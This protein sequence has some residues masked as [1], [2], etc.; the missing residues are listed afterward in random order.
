MVWE[1]HITKT[2]PLIEFQVLE[3]TLS[4]NKNFDYWTVF[5]G[6]RIYFKCFFVTRQKLV[7]FQGS[8]FDAERRMVPWGTLVSKWT[9]TNVWAWAG[10]AWER[11]VPAPQAREATLAILPRQLPHIARETHIPHTITTATGI[12]PSPE[13]WQYHFLMVIFIWL[14]QQN[15]IVLHF[16]VTD[17]LPPTQF[18]SLTAII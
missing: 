13:V 6:G 11:P 15:F 2:I 18:Q 8:I 17:V 16:K 12:S 7:H 10:E 14:I 9:E 1:A 5:W 4:E 3:E